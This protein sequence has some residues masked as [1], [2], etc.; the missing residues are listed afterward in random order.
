[1]PITLGALRSAIHPTHTALILGAGASVPSG[2]PTGAQLAKI[3]WRKVA[4]SDPKSD[5]LVETASILVRTH[6]RRPVVDAV[7]ATLRPL[8]PTGGLLGLPKF[9]W[10]QLFTTNFDRLIETA[11]KKNGLPIAV[12]RSNYDFTTKEAATGTR[13][14]KMHGCISQD[15]SLGNKASMILTEAD[16]ETYKNYRQAMFAELQAALLKGN[17]LILRQSLRDVHLNNLV[18][19]AMQARIE[20]A[21][22]HVYVLV[23]D[24]DDLRAP[25]LEDRGARIAFGAIDEFVH[26]MAEG[27]TEPVTGAPASD[28]V[29]PVGLIS[30]V[31]DVSAALGGQANVAKM[32]NGGPATYADIASD[33]TF[34]RTRYIQ[35]AARLAEDDAVVLVVTGAAGVGK[36]T[37]ARQLMVASARSGMLAWEHNRDFSFRYEQWIALEAQL[38]AAGRKAV[39]LVDECTHWMRATNTLVDQLCKVENAALRVILTGNSAQWVPRIKTPQI[40]S[41]RGAVVHLFQ[42]EQVELNSLLNLVQNNTWISRPCGRIA[43]SIG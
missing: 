21:P 10:R 43:Q 22:G 28:G 27:F 2:A 32:F 26:A 19:E 33:V 11:Y 18:K 8:Q 24:K 35:L 25:L 12:M 29:L 34:E 16:Y 14:F 7:I 36:T 4:N 13:L 17:V 1:M 5:D 9:G 41:K 40:F 42:L 20:G 30:T 6:S 31:I 37:F 23:Y 39:L 15:E 3:L 38:R